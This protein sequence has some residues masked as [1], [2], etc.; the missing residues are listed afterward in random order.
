MC[1]IQQRDTQYR[2]EIRKKEVSCFVMCIE[3]F[4]QCLFPFHRKKMPNF[5]RGCIKC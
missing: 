2:H 4:K 5:L 3:F 1:I